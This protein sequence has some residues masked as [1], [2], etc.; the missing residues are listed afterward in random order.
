LESQN[1]KI[2][3]LSKVRRLIVTV[4]F[5]VCALLVLAEVF[6]DRGRINF[7]SLA[8]QILMLSFVL[9]S[10]TSR[11]VVDKE[12]F[13]E[14]RL[15]IIKS[16]KIFWKNIVEV[17]VNDGLFSEIRCFLRTGESGSKSLGS[18]FSKSSLIELLEM[19][20][21]ENPVV[22]KGFGVREFENKYS[23]IGKVK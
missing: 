5:F 12:G 19:I 18:G 6:I 11:T 10:V 8:S 23:K 16:K 13:V 3:R 22:E 17:A 4:G 21:K 9:G 1:V 7:F 15:L 14:F 20:E 2:Y